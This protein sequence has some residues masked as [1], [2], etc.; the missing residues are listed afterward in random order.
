MNVIKKFFHNVLGWGYPAKRIPCN[1]YSF[2]LY[3]CKFCDGR[4]TQDSTGA[5]FHLDY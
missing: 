5:W 4:V 1:G 3:T 2:P